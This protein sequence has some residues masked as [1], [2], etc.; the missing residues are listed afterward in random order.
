MPERIPA[1]QAKLKTELRDRNWKLNVIMVCSILGVI[2]Q[3]YRLTTQPIQ[4]A[5]GNNNNVRIG[6]L[7]TAETAPQRDYLTTAEFAA[8]NDISERLVIQ[9][10]ADNRIHPAPTKPGRAWVI[11]ANSRILPPTTAISRN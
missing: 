3:F 4:P 9:L 2:F 11:A 7:K 6:E 5:A 1:M 10:I 8:A